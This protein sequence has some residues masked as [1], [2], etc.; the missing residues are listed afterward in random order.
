MDKMKFGSLFS[1]VGGFDLGLARAGMECAWQVEIDLQC[2]AVLEHHW[3]EVKR[4]GDITEVDGRELGGVDLVC[5]GFPCQDLSV[6]GRRAGLAGERSGLFH[7]FMRIVSEVSPR[8]VLIEN[9]PGLLSSN[10]GRDMGTVVGALGAFGYGWSYRVLDAQYFGL[11]QRRER[12][13][14][15]GC[16]GDGGSAAEVLLESESLPGNPAPS[17]EEGKEL[18]RDVAASLRGVG[19]SPRGYNL[20]AEQGLTVAHETGKGWWK[21]DEKAGTLRA[22]GENRPSRPSH[23]VA[24]FKSGQS[25]QSRSLGYAEEQSPTLP[26]NAG[27]NTAPCVFQCHGNNVGPMGSLRKGNGGITG[28]VPGVVTE[29]TVRRLTPVECCRLQGFPDD[30]LDVE[31]KGKPLSDSARYRMLGNAVAVPCAEWIGERIF[32]RVI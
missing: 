19:G 32:R 29:M 18:A 16:L 8:W 26:A 7:E 30:W 13:F 27:G 6:A 23:V 3:P 21:E 28:G 10:G 20:D 31:Y 17:R 15:V 22:E 12:V 1:G 2:G 4:N 11:A 25:A 14:I 5:G 9:V 24:A